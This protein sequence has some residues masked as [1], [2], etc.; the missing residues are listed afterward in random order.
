MK[1]YHCQQGTSEWLALRAGIPT[2]S[3]FD[4]IVTP[5]GKAGKPGKSTS[6]EKYMAH[7][8]A[9]RIL[10]RPIDGFKSKWM[11]L[12]NE[13][14]DSAVASY[15]FSRDCETYRVG[16]VTTD[17]GLIGCSPDRFIVGCDEGMLE[18]KAPSP[19]VHVSYMMAAAGASDE[20]KVQLMGQMW[21]CERDWVDI[22]SYAPDMPEVIYRVNRDDIYITEMAAMIRS[23]SNRLEDYAEDFKAKGYIKLPAAAPVPT[24]NPDFI[25]DEDVSVLMADRFP[26]YGF[27]RL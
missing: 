20:Y 4:S 26:D 18:A 25:T 17:D 5:G 7:L 11:E 1:V 22:I 6:Q 27:D 8:L 19:A 3:Q 12:G 13:Y 21:V 10:N 15:E 14:E 2:A 16:F 23:F 24:A 9:E